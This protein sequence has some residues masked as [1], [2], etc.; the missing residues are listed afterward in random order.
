MDVV[1]NFIEQFNGAFT[2][3]TLIS[4]VTG[5]LGKTFLKYSVYIAYF[6]FIFGIIEQMYHYVLGKGGNYYNIITRIL[7]VSFCLSFYSQI[8]GYPIW[9]MNKF[10][11]QTNVMNTISRTFQEAQERTKSVREESFEDQDSLVDGEVKKRKKGWFSFSG[12]AAKQTVFRLIFQ[13][14]FWIARIAVIVIILLRNVMLTF[15]LILG[16]PCIATF[17]HPGFNK[18]G[19]GWVDSYFNILSWIV[20][21]IVIFT[22][23]NALMQVMLLTN[24][25]TGNSII[26]IALNVILFFCITKIPTLTN[27][28]LSGRAG[29]ASSIAVATMA[30]ATGGLHKLG[31]AATSKT[32]R[33]LIGGGVAIGG[34]LANHAGQRAGAFAFSRGM[35]DPYGNLN[36]PSFNLAN[37]SL[38]AQKGDA[39]LNN[40]GK[41]GSPFG[42]KNE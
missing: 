21:M 24:I 13:V 16:P 35:I 14:T 33:D 5:D 27:D 28:L 8:V 1:V 32:T 42:S 26:V 41:L 11:S 19:N 2:D 3:E 22:V 34:A 18:W 31:Q 36:M 17:V 20:W 12:E 25:E 29:S 9:L 15:L 6:L 40:L 37:S 10:A 38:M 4:V 30:A 7:I 39:M 23:Y